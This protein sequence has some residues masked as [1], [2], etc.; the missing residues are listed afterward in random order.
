MIEMKV[1][2]V[3]FEEDGVRMITNIS[4]M[5]EE[6]YWFSNERGHLTWEWA[7]YEFQLLRGVWF[8]N[9]EEQNAEMVRALNFVENA[10]RPYVETFKANRGGS[11]AQII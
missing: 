8:C 1:I 11:A 4:A 6:G 7:P 5:S 2:S 9:G 3:A 10:M